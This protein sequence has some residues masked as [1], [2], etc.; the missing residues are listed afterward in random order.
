MKAGKESP[1][2]LFNR[3]TVV[4]WELTPT[5]LHDLA[6]ENPPTSL[7]DGLHCAGGNTAHH[8]DLSQAGAFLPLLEVLR[9]PGHRLVPSLTEERGAPCPRLCPSMG[10]CIQ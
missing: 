5:R 7:P 4:R 3:V 2:G 1:Q 8:R 9:L 10:T 6:P